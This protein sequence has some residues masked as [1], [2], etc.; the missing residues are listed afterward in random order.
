MS[1]QINQ[2]FCRMNRPTKPGQSC[3]G[4]PGISS[5]IPRM[6]SHQSFEQGEQPPMGLCPHQPGSR[7]PQ[8]ETP[9][10]ATRARHASLTLLISRMGTSPC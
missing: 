8:P 6:V 2:T 3:T 9:S 4:V 7:I 10:R 1:V 5:L